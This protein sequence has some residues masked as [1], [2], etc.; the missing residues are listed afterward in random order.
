[1]NLFSELKNRRVFATAALYIPAAWLGAEIILA[2]FDRFGAPAWAGDVVVVLFLL[3]FPV[4]LLLSW[5]FDVT[6]KGVRRA[7]PGTPLGIVVLLASGLFLSVG[8]YVSYQVFSGHHALIRLAV[9]PLRANSMDADSQ[10][11]GAGISDSLRHNLRSLPAFNIPARISSEAIINTGLDIPGI[12]AR[13]GVDYILEGSLERSGDSLNVAVTL[14][15]NDGQVLWSESY[16]RAIRELFSL[17]NDLAR[18]VATQLGVKESNPTLQAQIRKPP[19]TTDLEAHRLFLQGKYAPVSDAEMSG[20]IELLKAARERDP[21]Y[22]EVYP[23]IASNYAMACWGLDDR[24]APSCEMAINFAQQGSDLDPSLAEA[25]AVLALVHSVRYEWEKAFEAIEKHQALPNNQ[26]LSQM[27]PSAYLNL[28]MAQKAWDSGLEFYDNDPL[29]FFAPVALALWA[30]Y[31]LEEPETAD[32]YSA[33]ADELVPVPAL[34]NWPETRVHRVPLEQAVE[35][36]RMSAAMFNIPGE[37]AD[38]VIPVIYD[39]SLAEEAALELDAWHAEGKI[40]TAQYWS[41]LPYV[42][43]YD[44]FVEMSFDLYDQKM[45]NPVG[46]LAAVPGSSRIRSHPR[47]VE[48]VEYVGLAEFWDKHGWPLFCTIENGKRS[49]AEGPAAQLAAVE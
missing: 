8:A 33:I 3:G 34:A 28:G 15:D 30:W 16:Q 26:I 13:L 48:L 39:P 36:G 20:R 24:T 32:F 11:Y 23:A 1:M 42:Q 9:L 35:E 10:P 4:A 37:W 14:L 7:S 41:F 25:W 5:L 21:G 17:Q 29:N 27:L 22:A 6:G 31:W 46:L 38:V 12:A 19:P 47:F 49:C 2:I 45:L 18:A 43:R 44:Q 40:R